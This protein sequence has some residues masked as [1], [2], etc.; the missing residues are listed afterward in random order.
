VTAAFFI[1]PVVPVIF[2]PLIGSWRFPPDV[3][4]T[5]LVYVIALPFIF[6][7]GLPLFLLFSR[8]RMFR[9]WGAILAGSLGGIAI[10]A[11]LGGSYNLRGY[12]LLLYG[13][14]GAATGITFWAVVMLGPEPNQS[15]AK[16]WVEAYRQR[17]GT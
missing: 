4:G 10:D 3:M 6:L 14:T 7:I 15:T 9:W 17:R 12:P 13:A 2:I 1:A 5:L 16:H 11:L 8:L